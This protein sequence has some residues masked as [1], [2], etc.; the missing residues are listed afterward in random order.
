[1]LADTFREDTSRRV[2][3]QANLIFPFS[4]SASLIFFFHTLAAYP[5]LGSYEGTT[6]N[7][8]NEIFQCNGADFGELE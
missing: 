6:I 8:S 3:Y 7:D 5:D 4:I 2:P 1:M